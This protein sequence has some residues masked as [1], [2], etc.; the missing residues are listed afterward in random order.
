MRSYYYDD[1]LVRGARWLGDRGARPNHVT[2]LQLPVLLA[3]VLAVQ[4][5]WR[6]AFVALIALVVLLDALDGVLARVGGME[7]RAGAALDALFDTMGIAI[8]LW[9]A[10]VFEPEYATAMLLLF[11]GNMTLFLQNALL[12]RKVIAYLRGPVLIGVVAPAAMDG[13]VV[14]CSAIL[15]WLIAW[16]F[17]A[18]ARVLFPVKLGARP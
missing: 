9:G 11:L 18:T 2:F 14:L 7:T 1:L 6:V 5:G 3:E 15:V 12:G 16:R 4:Q 17:L 13:A 10:A 8:V